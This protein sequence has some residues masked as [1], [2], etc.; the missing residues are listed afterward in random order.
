STGGYTTYLPKHN[1]CLY[2]HK[3]GKRGTKALL[4]MPNTIDKK[5]QVGE[6]EDIE[7]VPACPNSDVSVF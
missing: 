1:F 7:Y 3:L 5:T 2:L 4:W 6:D